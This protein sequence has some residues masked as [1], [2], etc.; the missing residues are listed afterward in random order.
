MPELNTTHPYGDE[1]K[2][3]LANHPYISMATSKSLIENGMKVID[4]TYV[5]CMYFVFGERVP[6]RPGPFAQDSFVHS[7]T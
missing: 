3:A 2:A 7:W 6:K 4:G 5:A 1:T